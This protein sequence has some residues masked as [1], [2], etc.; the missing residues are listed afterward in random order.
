MSVEEVEAVMKGTDDILL[1]VESIKR[2]A[3]R[4]LTAKVNEM[5]AKLTPLIIRELKIEVDEKI[6]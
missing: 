1:R 5:M 4:K 2:E 3:G 6:E